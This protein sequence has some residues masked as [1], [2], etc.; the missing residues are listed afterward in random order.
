MSNCHEVSKYVQSA[1]LTL[2]VLLISTAIQQRL[3][4]QYY[5]TK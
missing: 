3:M 4:Y 2:H 1:W 5:V